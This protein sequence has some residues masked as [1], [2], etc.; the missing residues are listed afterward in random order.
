MPPA[1]SGRGTRRRRRGRRGSTGS[2][3]ATGAATADLDGDVLARVIEQRTVQLQPDDR[4]VAGGPDAGRR[5]CRRSTAAVLGVGRAPHHADDQRHRVAART[6][7]RSSQSR[8]VLRSAETSAP[9]MRVVVVLVTPYLRWS[10]PSCARNATGSWARCAISS[11]NSHV[12]AWAKA[13]RW[14]PHVRVGRGRGPTCRG[15]TSGYR[16]R[17]ITSSEPCGGVTACA[18][19]AARHG[20]RVPRRPILSY[21]AEP[22]SLTQRRDDDQREPEPPPRRRA[23]GPGPRRPTPAKKHSTAAAWRWRPEATTDRSVP[24]PV[25]SSSGAPVKPD[26]GLPRSR[27]MSVPPTARPVRPNSEPRPSI[28]SPQA[29]TPA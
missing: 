28:N 27:A 12:N 9:C 18:A 8:R 10:R 11:P 29:S 22:L 23:P 5:R 21:G 7:D 25:G 24:S 14:A 3:S 4:H 26:R 1:P 15:R 13:T 17:R 19:R 16:N 6:V 2:G 20:H